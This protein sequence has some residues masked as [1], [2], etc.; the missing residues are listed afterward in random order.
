MVAV[1]AVL[2]DF[3]GTA[4]SSDVAELLLRVYAD[5]S[6]SAYDD[7]VDRGEIGLRAAIQIQDAMLL[8]TGDELTAYAVQHCRLDPTFGPFVEWLTATGVEVALV[9]DGFGFYIRP[10][11][12]AAG[13]GDLDVMSNEQLWD[14][15]GRPAG[16]RFVNGHPTCVGCGTC[17]MNAVL[18]YRERHGPVAFV[19][20]GQSD[21]YGA[22]YA[23]LT[24]AK[25]ELVDHCIRD[26][27]PFVGWS[28]FDDVRRSLETT[29][30][31]PGP[32]APATCPGWTTPAD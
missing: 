4:S 26:G 21:R 25:G 15:G 13:L 31:L 27:V 10:I 3:D 1:G 32:A 17:K 6:W 9:S 5:P 23:D 8:A 12:E 28:D 24:F 16:M 30:A 2:V 22:L 14:A 20:D 11:L 18:R 7:A 19:G 29:T